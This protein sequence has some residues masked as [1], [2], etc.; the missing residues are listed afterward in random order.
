MMSINLEEISKLSQIVKDFKLD[1]LKI[2]DI[3]IVKTKHDN[4]QQ[5]A[6]P[7]EDLSAAFSNDELATKLWIQATS[8]E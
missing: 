3:E 7:K 6:K 5:L 1:S 8:K 2:G 4:V